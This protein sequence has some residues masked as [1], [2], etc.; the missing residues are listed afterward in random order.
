MARAD[1]AIV[2][3]CGLEC[4][5]C[6]LFLAANDEKEAETLVG[7]FRQQGWL[8]ENEGAAEIMARGPY[9]KGCHGDPAVQWSGDC[10]VRKCCVGE[11]H[12]RYCSE[13]AEFPCGKL[14]EWSK[15]SRRYAAALDR[16]KS[17]RGAG[18]SQGA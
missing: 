2:A 11:K 6:N 10:W 16:L 4:G 13:C 18:P 17:L 14:E 9:C 8:K 3:V 1:D 15:K 7:W 12:H 5:K